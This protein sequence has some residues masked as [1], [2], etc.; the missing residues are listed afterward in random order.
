MEIESAHWKQGTHI[1]CDPWKAKEVFDDIRKKHGDVTPELIVAK[2]KSMKKHPI[3]DEFEWDVNLAAAQAW[4]TRASHLRRSL[5]IVRSDA[6]HLG[7]VR[8]LEVI[9][10]TDENADKRRVCLTVDEILANPEAR[11]N[12][13]DRAYKDLESWR[14]RYQ[15]LEELCDIIAVIPKAA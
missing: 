9:T 8:Y 7:P 6:R 11:A 2:A 10:V 13:L 12:L 14:R 5:E 3:H 4:R 15:H 1:K